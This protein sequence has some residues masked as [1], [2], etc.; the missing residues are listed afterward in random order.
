MMS[1]ISYFTF[2]LCCLIKHNLVHISVINLIFL[3]C[4]LPHLSVPDKG[5]R[6]LENP[7]W[8]SHFYEVVGR[9]VACLFPHL[10]LKIERQQTLSSSSTETLEK[11]EQTSETIHSNDQMTAKYIKKWWSWTHPPPLLIGVIQN[12]DPITRA[13][14]QATYT[15]IFFSLT[16]TS[17]N[18]CKYLYLSNVLEVEVVFLY[19]LEA[20]ESQVIVRMG[21]CTLTLLKKWHSCFWI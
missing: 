20:V 13:N 11:W 4:D 7:F 12:C 1:L 19:G 16:I 21:E 8:R 2:Y 15:V 5:A 3:Q 17:C 18:W 14:A 9:E 10:S 6:Y